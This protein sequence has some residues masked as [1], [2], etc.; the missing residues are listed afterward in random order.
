MKDTLDE[1]YLRIAP[2]RMPEN[3]PVMLQ[4]RIVAIILSLHTSL[5]LSAV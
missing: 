3:V 5:V 4:L 1:G 2:V